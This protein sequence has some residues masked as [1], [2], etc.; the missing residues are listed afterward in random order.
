MKLGI[1][2]LATYLPY[3]LEIQSRGNGNCL[4]SVSGQTLT[5]LGKFNIQQVMD[6]E[7]K[8]ILRPLINLTKEIEING[9]KFIPIIEMIRK[10]HKTGDERL[11]LMELNDSRSTRRHYRVGYERNF[12]I[13]WDVLIFI[14]GMRYDYI[15]TLLEWHFD[16]FGLIDKKLAVAKNK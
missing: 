10:C 6:L 16:I 13:Y 4:L 14:D 7:L 1:Q 2:H 9:K 3:G 12:Y 5:E 8:P 15:Q 11:L